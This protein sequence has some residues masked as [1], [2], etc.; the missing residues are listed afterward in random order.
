MARF[1]PTGYNTKYRMFKE[2]EVFERE[3]EQQTGEYGE[4]VLRELFKEI[5]TQIPRIIDDNR[6]TPKGVHSPV[7]Y[8]QGKLGKSV[9][10]RVRKWQTKGGVRVRGY[11]YVGEGLSYARI[12]DFDG[13]KKIEAKTP[14]GLV[15]FEHRSQRWM[16]FGPKKIF[17]VKR[18]GSPYF[19]E[20]VN[21][22]L[23]KLNL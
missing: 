3:I 21:Y 15:F 7:G 8:V 11:L 9:R 14:R 6:K 13:I 10:F 18:P 20:A 1:V 16:G 23:A 19:D 17:V 22:S 5:K 12:H 2:L 4:E